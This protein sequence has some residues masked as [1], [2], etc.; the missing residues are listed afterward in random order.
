MQP[1]PGRKRGTLTTRLFAFF[2]DEILIN[3]EAT[4]G[5]VRVEALDE[6]GKSIEGF[7][8]RE[9][10]PLCGDELRYSLCWKNQNDCQA[11]QGRLIRLRFHLDQA[12]LFSFTPADH[13]VGNR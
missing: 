2:G 13:E 1:L 10:I 3:A 9:C 8:A 5:S 6:S 4:G 12:K 11:L 7:T